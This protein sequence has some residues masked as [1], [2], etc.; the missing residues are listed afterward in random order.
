VVGLVV[1]GNLRSRSAS[2]VKLILPRLENKN[3]GDK[4]GNTLL[5]SAAW[6]G[7]I[8]IVDFILPELE[9]MDKNPADK[10][11]YTPLHYAAL[12]H[13]DIFNLIHQHV[14]EVK[15]GW[16]LLYFTLLPRGVT[17]NYSKQFRIK[18]LI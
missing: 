13:L 18:S 8:S 3:P 14:I 10:H 17:L 7:H 5:H 16:T 9:A 1:S 2:I 12:G 11:G 4:E 6:N 15:N